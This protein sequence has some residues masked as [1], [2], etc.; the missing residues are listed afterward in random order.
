MNQST[1]SQRLETIRNRLKDHLNR[2]LLG[3]V[4]ARASVPEYILRDWIEHPEMIPTKEQVVKIHMALPSKHVALPANLPDD[5][6]A[7][8][9]GEGVT[10]FIRSNN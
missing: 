3:V 7:L 5:A 1:E 8:D 2:G 4:A 9:G 6:E 10:G